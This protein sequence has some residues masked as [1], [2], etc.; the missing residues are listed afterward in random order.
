[1]AQVFCVLCLAFT[2]MEGEHSEKHSLVQQGFS[3]TAKPANCFTEVTAP[4]AI[5]NELTPQMEVGTA[6]L[7]EGE[8]TFQCF[9]RAGLA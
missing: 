1:M 7:L 9:V 6:Y 8:H 3:N 4:I 5:C 2:E